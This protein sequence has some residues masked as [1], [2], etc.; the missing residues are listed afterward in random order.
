MN[1][2]PAVSTKRLKAMQDGDT[3]YCIKDREWVDDGSIYPRIDPT[4]YSVATRSIDSD[5]YYN[6]FYTLNIHHVLNRDYKQKFMPC[7]KSAGSQG[8]GGLHDTWVEAYKEGVT[9]ADSAYEELKRKV[10]DDLRTPAN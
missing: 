10:D 3:E 8:T 5:V 4:M 7:F 9:L 6:G 2:P 1:S